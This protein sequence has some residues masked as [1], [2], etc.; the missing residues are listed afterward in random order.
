MGKDG[1]RAHHLEQR[2][3][4]AVTVGGGR[5]LN[6]PPAFVRPQPPGDST[7]EL[8]LGALAKASGGKGGPHLAGLQLHRDFGGPDIAGD[9]DDLLHAQGPMGFCV[10]DGHA[11]DG[12]RP[13]S[14]VDDGLRLDAPALQANP[15]GKGLHH[16]AGLK[17]VGQR[18]VAQ[19]LTAQV[20]AFLRVVAGVV[21]HGQQ[22][23]GVGVQHHHATGMRAV[24]DH[25][26]FEFLV[27]E[28]LNLAVDAQLH[29]L[30]RQ[31]RHD[32]A[33]IFDHPSATVFDHVAQ[34]GFA[35][36]R[37]IEEEFHALLAL[38]FHIRKTDDV[39]GRFAFRVLAQVVGA[40]VYAFELQRADR[41]GGF[42]VNL[43]FHPDKIFVFIGP[44][45]TQVFDPHVQQ[46]GQFLRLRRRDV[47]IFGNRPDAGSR[48]AGCQDQPIA[49]EHATPVGR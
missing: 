29:V 27:S 30:T 2:R 19:L 35:G 22:L 46:F 25:G 37:L 16:R 48:N 17:G 20:G 8:D 4:Q 38:V 23:A 18:P 31:R 15:D 43:A 47:Y 33:H 45:F 49:V 28:K 5:L 24:V 39:G 3:G 32:R 44:F 41:F 40:L 13:G 12:D 11:G 7:L 1:V 36:K 6:R 26:L 21:G 10:A 42:G 9:L 14:G 34:T